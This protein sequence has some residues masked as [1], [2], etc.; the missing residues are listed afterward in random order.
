MKD[1][2]IVIAGRSK[3]GKSSVAKVIQDALEA[4]NVN[5]RLFDHVHDEYDALQDK[6][7]LEKDDEQL[8]AF[9]K[10]VT[11]TR[12]LELLNPGEE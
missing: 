8:S 3:Q 6:P 12:N 1:V 9:I 11:T 4:H 7:A 5:V 10:V 2:T